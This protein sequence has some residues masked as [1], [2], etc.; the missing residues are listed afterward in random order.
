MHAGSFSGEVKQPAHRL[1]DCR[2]QSIELTGAE[3]SACAYEVIS[4]HETSVACMRM[5]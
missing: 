4:E 5:T 1:C 2:I 3:D